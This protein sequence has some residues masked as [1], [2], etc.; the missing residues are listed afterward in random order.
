MTRTKEK[1]WSIPACEGKSRQ[2]WSDILKPRYEGKKAGRREGRLVCSKYIRV[3]E[4]IAELAMGIVMT[5]QV[6]KIWQPL[7]ESLYLRWGQSKELTPM[8]TGLERRELLFNQRE[9]LLY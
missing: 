4:G 5:E 3:K 8:R 7:V 2:T 9:K 1:M 6:L